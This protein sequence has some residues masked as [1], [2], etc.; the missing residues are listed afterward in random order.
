MHA[1]LHQITVP[2][3]QICLASHF[4]ARFE[5]SGDVILHE[6]CISWEAADTIRATANSLLLYS[7][8][9]TSIASDATGITH[10]VIILNPTRRGKIETGKRARLS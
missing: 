10:I 6:D 1:E 7:R 3:T 5:S 8:H 2:L 4:P 9:S